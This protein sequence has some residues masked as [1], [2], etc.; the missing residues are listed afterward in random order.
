M[1][2]RGE[3]GGIEAARQKH[4]VIMTPGDRCYF[5]H[6][7]ESPEFAP[8]AIGGFLPLDSVYAYDPTPA[9]LTSEE[10]SYIIGTQANI[11]GEYIQ[12]PEYFEYM[13]F[14]ACWRCLKCNGHNREIRISIHSS[15]GWTK[16][17]GDWIF[18]E[19]MLAGT[20]MK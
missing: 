1:S 8:L 19:L 7:Q 12:T 11:W 13:A 9:V 20:F 6:Y 10:Q 14:P 17:S 18:A 15:A 3:E 4:K 16:S 5:D 2:W